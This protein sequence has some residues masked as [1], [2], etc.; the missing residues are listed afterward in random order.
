MQRLFFREA[1][2]FLA[3]TET[4]ARDPHEILGVSLIHDGE[5]GGQSGTAPEL[6]EQT[7]ACGVKGS[8]MDARARGSH[9]SFGAREHFLCG[10]ARKSE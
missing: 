5:L 9:Q 3:D 10:P 1:L 7:I 6:A 4:C 2:V 8:A